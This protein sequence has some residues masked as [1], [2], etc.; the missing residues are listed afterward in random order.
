[1]G[2]LKPYPIARKMSNY[3][4]ESLFLKIAHNTTNTLCN[5]C[6][7]VLLVMA[8]RTRGFVWTRN[9]YQSVQIPTFFDTQPSTFILLLSK[10][11]D[12]KSP[13]WYQTISSQA[14]HFHYSTMCKQKGA[15]EAGAK[16]QSHKDA[17]VNFTQ[18]NNM[19][20]GPGFSSH[21]MLNSAA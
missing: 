17:A 3:Q 16:K 5:I 6:F 1:M 18:V 9:K 11:V 21:N 12:P 14:A 4:I 19:G 20:N 8:K 2:E 13:P 7:T 15:G 10:E